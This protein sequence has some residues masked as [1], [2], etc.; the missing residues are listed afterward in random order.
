MASEPEIML[1]AV[2]AP[3]PLA[4]RHELE[5]GELVAQVRKI[6]LVMK[7]VMRDGEHFGVIPGTNKPTLYKAGAEKLCVVFRLR[8]EFES[9]EY[10]DGAHLT[11]KSRCTLVHIPTG[12]SFGTGEGM[13]ST[14]ES[15]YGKRK[16]ERLCPQCG[17]AA[18]IKGKDFKT[19]ETKGQGWVCWKKKD[20]CNAKFKD[21][22]P[23]IES[24]ETGT[25]ENPDLPDLYNTVLKMANK[26]AHTAAVLLSTAASDIFTQ[27]LEDMPQ[28]QA[29]PKAERK[30]ATPED[31]RTEVL[32]RIH[33]RLKANKLMSKAGE[34]ERKAALWHAFERREW[35][36]V[37]KIEDIQT[38]RDGLSVLDAM[39][40]QKTHPGDDSVPFGSDENPSRDILDR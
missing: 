31:Q 32:M 21:G 3:A 33:A 40:T 14:K 37:K 39:L 34:D 8:P 16:G 30:V 9:V 38:L 7:E 13:C 11:V 35:D 27:D 17:V 4:V 5:V 10:W 25:V 28:A 26:R 15:K 12:Q 24:Q 36:E 29:A 1:P 20:G 23:A 2:Q 22:D 6:Q 19:G 18:I